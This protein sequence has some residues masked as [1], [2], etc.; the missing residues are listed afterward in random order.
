M[1]SNRFPMGNSLKEYVSGEALKE[2]K[3]SLQTGIQ[4]KN[5]EWCWKNEKAGLKTHRI[6]YKRYFEKY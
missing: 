6:S 3:S 2:L 1:P 5:C 4:H